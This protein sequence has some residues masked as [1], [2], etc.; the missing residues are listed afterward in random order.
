MK[1]KKK[2][3]REEEYEQGK[4]I[5]MKLLIA[6]LILATV[7]IAGCTQLN[8]VVSCSPNWKLITE[9]IPNE[10][11]CN[12]ICYQNF[13]SNHFKLE[14]N[15]FH[16]CICKISYVFNNKT[17]YNNVTLGISQTGNYT[18]SCIDVCYKIYNDTE[19]EIKD[20]VISKKCYCD[21]NNCNP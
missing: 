8:S 4:K 6:I 12:S 18:Q 5:N 7:L 14:D 16:S 3:K 11:Y 15:V 21:V 19:I 17:F 1:R 10:D 9:F 20:D 13:K 2:Q